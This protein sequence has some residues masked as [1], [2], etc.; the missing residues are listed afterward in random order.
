LPTVNAGNDLVV[1]YNNV[2]TVSPAYSADVVAWQWSPG[3]NGLGCASCP[4]FNGTAL[5][6]AT[7]QIEV[8]NIHGCMAKDEVKIIVDCSKANLLLPTA[9]TPDNNGRNDWFYP[10]TRGYRSINKMVVYNRW[11]NKVFER[12][13]FAP[14]T[15]SLG[16]N[17]KTSDLQSMDTGVYV[18]Y[19]EATC[20][21]GETVQLKGTVT[22]LR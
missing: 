8:K 20:D 16:W 18:W 21:I 7:H 11:G 2:F 4:V 6:T 3:L 5:Q 19:I 17:G 13:N 12:N 9:F 10:L 15:A 22:L 1:P 14:N